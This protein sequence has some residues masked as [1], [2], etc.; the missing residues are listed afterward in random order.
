MKAVAVEEFGQ[1][2]RLMVLPRPVP[3]PDEILVRLAAGSP[4]PFDRAIYEGFLRG[5]P[6]VFPLVLGTDGA[7]IVEAIGE[8]VKRFAVGD[9]VYGIFAHE[10]LGKGT[11]AEYVAAPEDVW[12]TKAPGGSHSANPQRRRRRA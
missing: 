12:V 2:P 4:N 9:A 8:R 5:L 1:T 11:L 7:G 6:H 3:G 10:P